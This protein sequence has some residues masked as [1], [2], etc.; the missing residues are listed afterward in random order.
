MDT[1]SEPLSTSEP[2]PVSLPVSLRAW[3]EID[4]YA[5]EWFLPW[6]NLRYFF[7]KS[8]YKLYYGRSRGEFCEPPVWSPPAVDSFDLCGARQDF[9]GPRLKMTPVMMA[10]RDRCV[11]PRAMKPASELL[12]SSYNRD[13]VIKI[14]AKG[15]DGMKELEILQYINSEPLRSDPRNATVPVL[16]FLQYQDWWFAVMPRCDQSDELP[17]RDAS[18]CLEFA[19]QMLSDV[20]N[21]NILLNHRG[22]LPPTFMYCPEADF[23]YVNIWP[24]HPW[25]STFPVRY[26]FIDFGYSCRFPP[27][28]PLSE[29]RVIPR[30]GTRVHR[31][32]EMSQNGSCNPFAVD[33]YQTARLFY[34]WFA[35]RTFCSFYLLMQTSDCGSGPQDVI[36]CTPG[37]PRLLQDMTSFN[38]ARR[39][40][41]AEAL[42]RFHAV[43]SLFPKDQLHEVHEYAIWRFPL[44]PRPHWV[45]LR[46]LFECKQWYLAYEYTRFVLKDW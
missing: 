14:V 2:C 13:V 21:E 19:E 10:A 26:L 35:V 46:D 8:G 5:D 24:P 27:H 39:P 36:H 28:T 11:V 41:A 20:S 31:P 32:A 25:R 7:L 1:S 9:Q 30:F 33:V 44:V 40:S 29:C 37:F 34:G 4:S 45:T 17:F 18:E 6:E 15:E 23:P 42:D 22:E 43:R 38:P 3:R 12:L 16:E